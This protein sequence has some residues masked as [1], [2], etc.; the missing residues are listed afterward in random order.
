MDKLYNRC[1]ELPGGLILENQTN[2]PN[3]QKNHCPLLLYAFVQVYMEDGEGHLFWWWTLSSLWLEFQL[4]S[5]TVKPWVVLF[6]QQLSAN[7]GCFPD[8]Q[9]MLSFF[10]H[11]LQNHIHHAVDTAYIACSPLTAHSNKL[12][13]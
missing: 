1:R 3:K 11:I 9:A 4:C 8:C 6:W 12:T 2:Q 13:P 7:I 10:V 5:V